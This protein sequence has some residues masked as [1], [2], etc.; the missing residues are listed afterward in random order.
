VR[1]QSFQ[2][3]KTRYVMN[4]KRPSIRPYPSPA[5]A[6]RSPLDPRDSGA[7][8]IAICGELTDKQSELVGRLVEVPRSS[9]VTIF[10]DS[11]GGSA[12]VG[13]GLA[14]LIRLRGLDATGI[15]AGECSSAALLPF[16]ACG[17]RYVTPHSTLLFHPVRWQSEED[18]RFEEAAEWTRHFRE[19]EQDLD[20]LLAKMFGCSEELLAGWT[21]PGRFI[22]GTELAE[23]GLAKIVDLFSGDV[24][25]QIAKEGE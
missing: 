22:T 24:W 2:K 19:M 8:E 6:P 17:R 18:V 3:L 12:Y 5:V 15:V 9:K 25:S 4:L 1:R 14:T 16:A 7:Y 21:R 11:G 10:F 20:K 23:A 13:L